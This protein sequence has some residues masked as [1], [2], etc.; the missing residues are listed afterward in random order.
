MPTEPVSYWRNPGKPLDKIHWINPKKGISGLLSSDLIQFYVEKAG[1]ID[2]FRPENLK[3]ASYSLTL[4]PIYQVEGKDGLLTPDNQT[5][6]IPPNE[7]AYVSMRERLQLPHYIAARFNLSIKHVYQ[8]LLLGTGPQVDPGFQGV[9]SCP[10]YNLSNRPIRLV[11]DQH[12]ATIDFETTTGFPEAESI[13]E[14]V[15]S[16]DELYDQERQLAAN[17]HV[18]LFDLDKRWNEPVLG[19]TPG[20]TVIQSSLGYLLAE[21]R[22]LRGNLR[23][24]AFVATIAV[25]AV[26]AAVLSVLAALAIGYWQVSTDNTSLRS[27]LESGRQQQHSCFAAIGTALS[28]P[29]SKGLSALPVEC[30]GL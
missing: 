22:H 9:L 11:L 19:Y 26:G 12:L 20:E 25:L 10:L 29:D 4:G 28:R 1:M 16:E 7:L 18:Y 14:A 3:P 6:T 30:Q 5:L 27:E 24:G 17:Q 2:P 8:G 21:V 15:E 23:I 13:L